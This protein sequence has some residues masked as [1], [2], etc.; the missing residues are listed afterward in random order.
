MKT[1]VW[2][3]Y[4]ILERKLGFPRYY[5]NTET[6]KLKDVQRFNTT[7][8]SFDKHHNVSHNMTFHNVKSV[9]YDA[10]QN[11]MFGS[12]DEKPKRNPTNTEKIST[13][14]QR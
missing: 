2:P 7:D 11:E 9:N 3:L 13:T 5:G 12:F 8:Y 14:L 1:Q 10:N 6:K 4:F